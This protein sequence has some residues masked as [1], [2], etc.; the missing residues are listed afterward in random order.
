MAVAGVGVEGHVAEHADIGVRALDRAHGAADEIVRID[1]LVSLLALELG[2][3]EG[4]E[5]HAGNAELLRLAHGIDE[6]REREALHAGHGGN[7]L[8]PALALAQEDRPDQIVRAEPMLGD[9]A[10]GPGIDAVAAH[11][12]A[13]VGAVR[14]GALYGGRGAADDWARPCLGGLVHGPENRTEPP[15]MP[16]DSRAGEPRPA[17]QLTG[18][19]P[20]L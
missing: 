7:R 13:R 17:P 4:E 16:G 14:G 15:S 2:V 19:G 10:P 11:A 12:H 9:Q 6:G 18:V 1:R 8:A 3:G 20:P 5:R